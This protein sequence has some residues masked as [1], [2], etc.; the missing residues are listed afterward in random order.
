MS[1]AVLTT[2]P[3][4]PA[5]AVQHSS[6]TPAPSARAARTGLRSPWGRRTDGAHPPAPP[7]PPRRM[8]RKAVARAPL[9]RTQLLVQSSLSLFAVVL[10]GFL[11]NVT[12]LSQ[13]QHVISQQQLR[14]TLA[15]QLAAGS[16]PVSEGTVDNV[17][18]SDG[19]PVAWIEIPA[20]GVDEVVVE[21]TSSGTLTKGPGHRRDT[22]LPGQV[23]ISVLMGRAYAYG[24]PFGTIQALSPGETL[25]VITGQGEHIYRVLGVRYA[26]D[27][28]VAYTAGTS[29][30]VLET[31]RG[32]PFMPTGVVRVDAELVSEVKPYGARQT[33]WATLAAEDRELAS[34]PSTVWA[35][36]FALQFLVLAEVAAVYALHRFGAAKTWVVFVPV[37]LLGGLLVADQ[38][39]RL[40]PNLL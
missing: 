17:L 18:L 13:L 37:L 33:T 14:A 28:T 21:G 16:A 24:G 29:R 38:I 27:P 31:A 3:S 39:T 8:P 40:L 23:G 20:L 7:R 4:L 26:G 10:L 35:L 6:T 30:L 2:K 36:V 22:V 11:A 32:G 12:V 5:G 9:T 34:D 1:E 15:E 25:S 19:D